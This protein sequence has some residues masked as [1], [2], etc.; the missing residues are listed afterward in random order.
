M[1]KHI[2]GWVLIL[3][4]IVSFAEAGVRRAAKPL[5]TPMHYDVSVNYL[6]SM[7]GVVDGVLHGTGQPDFRQKC[8]KCLMPFYLVLLDYYGPTPHLLAF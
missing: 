1:I 7:F 6:A 3:L 5:L 2:I 8:L 4:P